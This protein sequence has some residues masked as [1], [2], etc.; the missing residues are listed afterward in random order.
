MYVASL[1]P[2]RMVIDWKYKHDFAP[3]AFVGDAVLAWRFVTMLY[4]ELD[5]DENAMVDANIKAWNS[6]CIDQGSCD[7]VA[8]F[9][10]Y[11]NLR[12]KFIPR[13]KGF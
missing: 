6:Y 2:T 5:P 11:R 1:D 9:L 12:N 3:A 7:H 4:H 8:A 13:R 10:P